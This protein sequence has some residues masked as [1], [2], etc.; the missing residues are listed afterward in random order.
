[1]ADYNVA[2]TV[3][4]PLT[5]SIGMFREKAIPANQTNKKLGR[6][7][8]PLIFL[9]YYPPRDGSIRSLTAHAR[10]DPSGSDITVQVF[11][12]DAQPS[13]GAAWLFLTYNPAVKTVT[14]A[15]ASGARTFK[16]LD[17]VSIVYTTDGDFDAVGLD[18]QA[19]LEVEL[20]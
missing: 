4:V 8:S 11:V 7:E 14:A 3:N 20:D 6:A 1:M 12:N 10:V 5:H 17:K 9:Y 15:W 19:D 16:K 13:E 2:Q 18:L